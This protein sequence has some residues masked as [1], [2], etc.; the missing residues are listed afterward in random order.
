MS[1][2]ENSEIMV[3]T[4]VY[5]KQTTVHNTFT[6][7]KTLPVILCNNWQ[8]LLPTICPYAY[9]MGAEGCL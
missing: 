1:F 9:K 7:E 4:S 3:G 8:L 2:A 6:A 5:L